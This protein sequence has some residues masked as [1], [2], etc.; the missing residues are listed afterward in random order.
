MH[1]ELRRNNSIGNTKGILTFIRTV[2]SD[3]PVKMESARIICQS[4]KEIILSF[5]LAALFFEFL[6]LIECRAKKIL[7]TEIGIQLNEESEEKVK[8]IL[9]KICLKKVIQERILD[10]DRIHFNPVENYYY[11]ER[12]GFAFSAAIFRNTLIQLGALHEYDNKLIINKRFEDIFA[13]EQKKNRRKL[14][15][16]QLKEKLEA[17]E[18]QGDIAEEFVV[19]FEQKRIK[20]LNLQQ[21]IKRISFI[22]V[23]AGYDIVSFKSD[24]SSDYD[25]FIEVKS[26]RDR[27][28]FYWSKNEMDTAMALGEKYSLYLVDVNRIKEPGY[29]PLIIV[30]PYIQIIKNN[31]GLWL[32]EPES[33]SIT[34]I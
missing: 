14:T 32:L 33:Y 22:D 34:K 5:N 28:H 20:N 21:Q 24:E 8:E 25:S 29:Q 19:S 18:Q 13:K 11:I 7:S 10:D 30:D 9:C 27:P 2:I 16:E 31:D 6:G 1:E 17:Q 12:Q 26:F 23:A 4:Q 15:L 3:S